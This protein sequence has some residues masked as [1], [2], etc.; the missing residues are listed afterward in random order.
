MSNALVTI[1]LPFYNAEN[2]LPLAIKST[3][4]QTF[5][6]WRLLLVDDGSTDRSLAIAK[7]FAEHDFR[8]EV[9]TDGKNRGLIYRLNQLIDLADTKY[10]ARMDADDIMLPERLAKQFHFLEKNRD[11]KW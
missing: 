7:E 10:I 8:I 6:S 4:A 2:T 1:G 5:S 11:I 3:L 9:L